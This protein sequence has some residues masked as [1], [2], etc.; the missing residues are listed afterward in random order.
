MGRMDGKVALISGAGRGQGRSHA[1][2]L[3]C[4]GADFFAR[5][6]AAGGGDPQRDPT[7][8]GATA[9]DRYRHHQVAGGTRLHGGRRG[10]GSLEKLQRGKDVWGLLKGRGLLNPQ[11]RSDA[12]LFP[13]WD[14]SKDIP[15]PEGLVDAGH[16]VLPGLNTM[17][18]GAQAPAASS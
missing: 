15:G 7:Q 12:V 6:P 18:M 8:R 4:E 1:L 10:L 5:L 3:A 13:G 16:R 9:H 11:S 17:E 14:E 2:T